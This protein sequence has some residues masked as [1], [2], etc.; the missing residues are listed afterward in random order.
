MSCSSQ[1]QKDI[2]SLRVIE[3]SLCTAPG[4]PLPSVAQ[5]GGSP[6]PT[7]QPLR[8]ALPFC[9]AHNWQ[10]ASQFRAGSCLV[11]VLICGH[12]TSSLAAAESLQAERVCVPGCSQDTAVSHCA[13][14]MS[15]HTHQT[16]GQG[17]RMC[18]QT[19]AHLCMHTA[20]CGRTEVRNWSSLQ[21]YMCVHTQTAL[22]ALRSGI[23]TSHTCTCIHMSASSKVRSYACLHMDR[24][25]NPWLY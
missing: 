2:L 12:D 8:M 1:S 17:L 11:P 19:Q 21:M 7:S 22:P 18:A 23:G 14:V 20:W 13:A 25:T 6:W 10:G 5:K 15:C 4:A 16:Q 9:V 24:H 3:H